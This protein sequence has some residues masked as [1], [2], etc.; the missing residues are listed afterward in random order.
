VAAG[1]ETSGDPTGR[2]YRL[3]DLFSGCG[4]LSEGFRKTGRFLS[5]AAV[6]HDL[7]AAA[8]YAA[9][10]GDEHVFWG[11]IADWMAGDLPEADVIVG[12][13]PCQGFSN[14]GT[15][16]VRDPRNALWRRY[17]DAVVRIQPRVFVLENVP[18]FAKSGQFRD[19]FRE[20]YRSGRIR[21]YMLRWGIVRATDYGAAQMRTRFIAIG[22]HL[23]HP[24]VDLPHP[25]VAE[26]DW[27]TVRHAIGDLRNL[28]D[29]DHT[30]LP[31]TTTTFFG[32]HV[33]GIY[34]STDLDVAR[35]YSDISRRR[36]VHIPEGGN[37]FDL[38]DDLK[39]PCWLKPHNGA[40]D[41]L[42]RLRWDRPSVT[43]RTEFHKPEKGRY[44]HPEEHRALT[45]H[46][47][48]RLQGF[49]D[50]FVW[51]GSKIQIARQIGNA[52]PVQL[53]HQLAEHIAA[54][55]RQP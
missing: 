25:T 1:D 31:A 2:R 53:S 35:T 34:K 3:V 15:R 6:E 48:A 5:V 4:G 52:V 14:L 28:V 55:L 24:T 50:N 21:N 8:T 38:P 44:L 39:A 11:D 22:T 7:F 42:G 47:A 30:T 23:D 43:I 45:H 20:T 27:R 26:A 32:Q 54:E 17:L 36:F 33:E 18:Q 12:G 41:V 51:C 37:R 29:P 10:F 49:D 46:E 13:P 16:R 40:Y 19:L 9:N